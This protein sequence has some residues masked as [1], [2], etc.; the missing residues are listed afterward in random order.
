MTEN[1]GSPVQGA[2]VVGRIALLLRLV[3]RNPAGTPLAEIV[4]DSGL[5]R[6]TVHRLLSSLAA[7][8]ILDHDPISHTWH[9]GPEIFVMGA[10][11]AQRYPIEE[12]ARPSLR[13]LAEESGES[14]FLSIRRGAETV[15]LLREEGSFPIRSFVLHEGVRFPLGV[16]S[17][18]IA[19]L[20][21]LPDAEVEQLL[22]QD[23]PFV[24]R[25]G[26]EH[27]PHAI[28]A[29]LSRTRVTGYSV[30]PGLIFEGSWGM[31][32]AIFDRANRPTWALSLTGIEPRFRPERQQVLGQLLLEE[33]NRITR[34]L[35]KP[36]LPGHS[37]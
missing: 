26:E 9:Y 20:A 14:A 29:N 35:Q 17:A 13:R 11:A 32:A 2:Q 5:T 25:W 12:L 15:C 18:G 36:G 6:P 10:V 8:G 34:L 23:E 3:G 19:I 4:R 22:V 24:A 33:A 30:N 16:A 21:F 37:A 1:H 7:E 28:R 31:G 27:S